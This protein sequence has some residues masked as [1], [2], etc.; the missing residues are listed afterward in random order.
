MFC[1]A[2]AGGKKFR[3]LSP[4]SGMCARHDVNPEVYLADVLIRIQDHPKSALAD[5]LPHRWKLTHGSG[6]TVDR[7][8]APSDVG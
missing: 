6:F 3:A 5:L 7:V 1:G 4:L 8:V 2:R